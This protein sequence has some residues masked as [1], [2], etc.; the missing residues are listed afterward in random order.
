MTT[1]SIS[2]G[3]HLVRR[4]PFRSE[5][6]LWTG[7]RQMV[8]VL[9]PANPCDKDIVMIA[10]NVGPQAALMFET[11]IRS[12]GKLE[13]QGPFVEGERV[14]VF[15][16]PQPTESFGDLT[17]AAQSSLDIWDKPLDDED[18]NNA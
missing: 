15:V 4:W 17:D 12:D 5:A 18:W 9:M 3:Q 8:K 10:T 16:V 2:H 11:E 14:V 6:V 13:L 1:T 7:R